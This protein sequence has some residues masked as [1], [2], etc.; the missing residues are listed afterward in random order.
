MATFRIA[1][2]ALSLL[3]PVLPASA[4][5]LCAGI[6]GFEA[7]HRSVL[8]P[9]DAATAAPGAATSHW[10]GP[11]WYSTRTPTLAISSR[12]RNECRR[13]HDRRGLG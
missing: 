7:E 12:S 5:V 1:T 13:S 11:R 8:K 10:I 6:D 9:A 3:R 4:A 2:L